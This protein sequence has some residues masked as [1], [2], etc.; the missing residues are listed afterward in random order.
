MI[1]QT[2][3]V[4]LP[5]RNVADCLKLQLANLEVALP[6]LTTAA[7]EVVI[8]DDAS[9]DATLIVLDDM[10]LRFPFLKV[11]LHNT[12]QGFEVAKAT[13]LMKAAGEMLLIHR[14]SASLDLADLQAL[15]NLFKESDL[16]AARLT[17][18][19]VGGIE[20]GGLELIHRETLHR[21]AI[22]PIGSYKLVGETIHS[23]ERFRG[24]F[25]SKNAA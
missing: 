23:I 15:C 7:F 5:V 9:D 3:S 6:K 1:S 2:I 19:G 24:Q 25:L 20:E 10:R 21:A 12:Q 16:V 8:V 11:A 14:G 17:R 4:I 18:E 22:S 13:G